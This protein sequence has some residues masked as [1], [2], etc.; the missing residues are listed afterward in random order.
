MSSIEQQRH[1]VTR[2]IVHLCLQTF[3]TGGDF[4]FFFI[5][6][7]IIHLKTKKSKREAAIF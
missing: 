7:A 5:L 4:P 6:K 3:E 1:V 2:Y